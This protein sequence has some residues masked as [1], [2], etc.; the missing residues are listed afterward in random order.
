MLIEPASAE[1]V[2]AIKPKP[3]NPK[4]SRRLHSPQV[5]TPTATRSPSNRT[6]K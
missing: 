1:E 5:P 3:K 6:S 4:P 2:D